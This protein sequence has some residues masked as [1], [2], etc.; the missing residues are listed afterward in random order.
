MKMPY[1]KESMQYHYYGKVRNSITRTLD[2]KILRAKTYASNRLYGI[3]LVFLFLRIAFPR[4]TSSP[5]T[6]AY[7]VHLFL[8]SLLIASGFNAIHILCGPYP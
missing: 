7:L 3:L 6:V 5:L 1:T 8:C 4:F 2:P